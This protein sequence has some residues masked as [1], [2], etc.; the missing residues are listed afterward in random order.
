M[1]SQSRARQKDVCGEVRDHS[2]VRARHAVRFLAQLR[3]GRP[4]LADDALEEFDGDGADEAACWDVRDARGP[5]I[6][7]RGAGSKEGHRVCPVEEAEPEALP[8]RADC[9]YGL[10]VW[11][12]GYVRWH[13]GQAP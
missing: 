12:V 11:L 7:D 5:R 3:V 1:Y 8:S 2:G 10:F 9:F 6:E 13:W 4:R